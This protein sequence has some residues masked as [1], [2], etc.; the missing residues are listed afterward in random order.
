VAR[1]VCEDSFVK[2]AS[3][4]LFQGAQDT[5]RLLE[6]FV[7]ENALDVLCLQEANDWQ[8]GTP[9][10]LEAFAAATGL[11]H[12]VFGDSNTQY[13]LATFSRYAISTS[14]VYTDGLWHSAIRTRIQ[15]PGD[16]TD[17]WNVH[18]NPGTEDDR[19]SEAH[20]IVPRVDP[21]VR[22]A[23]TGDFNSLSETD[24]YPDTLISELTA[25]GIEKFG[26][27]V[28]RFDVTNYLS[29][30]GLIDVA[31]ALNKRACTVP[32]PANRDKFHA[33]RMRLDYMFVTESLMRS[34]QSIEVPRDTLTDQISDHYPV[35][36]TA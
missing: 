20:L 35:I 2:L 3:Y 26:A 8:N 10:Q 18:L 33:A 23:I 17:I 7:R 12:Y 34:V 19:L 9:S 6:D 1:F 28:L 14:Q 16:E 30:S 15:T 5:I 11:Q 24:E 36:L 27:D 32:T 22:T 13:K 31:A 21:N 25:Q 29:R 4:N